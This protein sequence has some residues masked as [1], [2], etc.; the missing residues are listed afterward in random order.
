M[1]RRRVDPL[2]APRSDRTR[3]LMNI[4]SLE[5]P[6]TRHQEDRTL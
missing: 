1:G 2:I 6:P 5:E 3:R 4:A